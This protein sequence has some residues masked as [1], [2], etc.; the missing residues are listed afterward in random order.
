MSGALDNHEPKTYTWELKQQP[1]IGFMLIPGVLLS[2]SAPYIG[3]PVVIITLIAHFF[4]QRLV[5]NL[6][7]LE[8]SLQYWTSSNRINQRQTKAS[9]F[10]THN[11]LVTRI[12]QVYIIEFKH[13]EEINMNLAGNRLIFSD[14]CQKKCFID[15]TTEE[16]KA[17]IQQIYEIVQAKRG[18][19]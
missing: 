5:F 10:N 12:G 11:K 4:K 15:F 3:I 13:L 16:S 8:D 6:C 7:I 18:L 1:H 9:A 2:F 17:H 14:D 19:E